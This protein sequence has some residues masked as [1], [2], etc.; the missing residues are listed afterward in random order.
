MSDDDLKN[1]VEELE[2]RLGTL[3]DVHAIRRLHHLYEIGRAHV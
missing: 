3:E 2:D 1:R